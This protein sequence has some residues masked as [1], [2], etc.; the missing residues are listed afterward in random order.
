METLWDMI[1]EADIVV[2]HNGD[3]FDVKTMNARFAVHGIEAPSSYRTVDTLK[4]ARRKFRFASN[5]LDYLGKILGVGRKIETGGWKLWDDIVT[6]R[7]KKAFD[8]MVEYNIQD[9]LL[10]EDVY[11][12]LAPWDERHPSTTIFGALDVKACNICGSEKL[13]KNGSYATNTQ[14]YQKYKCKD[15]GHNMRSRKAELFEK[16]QKENLLRSL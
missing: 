3:N 14:K 6:H 7:D 11:K 15:C 4:I 9:V 13:Q 2:G 5:K 12:E 16:E 8:K 10:L 1:N